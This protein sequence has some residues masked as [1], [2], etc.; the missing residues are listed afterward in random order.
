MTTLIL[1]LL[2]QADCTPHLYKAN[3]GAAAMAVAG[4]LAFG[5]IASG[6]GVAAVNDRP[7]HV[8]ARNWMA[9]IGLGQFVVGLVLLEHG[10]AS[11]DVGTT[12]Y[13]AC[14]DSTVRRETIR[15]QRALRCACDP[16]APVIRRGRLPHLDIYAHTLN[17]RICNC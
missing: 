2:L 15:W 3:T 17:G 10:R 4:T 7:E 11:L 14:R 16:G 13:E 6:V 9:I 12:R 1:A 8:D 5:A